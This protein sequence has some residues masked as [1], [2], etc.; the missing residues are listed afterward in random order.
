MCLFYCYFVVVLLFVILLFVILL[1]CCWLLLIFL[2]LFPR[3]CYY[4]VV[5]VVVENEMCLCS[6]M[7]L[8]HWPWVALAGTGEP[9]L[10]G[11]PVTPGDLS[12]AASTTTKN[13]DQS[14]LDQK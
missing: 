12:L 3:F 6:A 9:F 1:F 7:A 2:V 11:R 10:E 8:I 4:F 13:N 14:F 5:V